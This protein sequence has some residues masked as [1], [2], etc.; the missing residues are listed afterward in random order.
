[1][2]KFVYVKIKNVYGKELVYPDCKVSE[3]I[4]KLSNKKTLNDNDLLAMEELGYTL[5]TRT[6]KYVSPCGNVNIT[7]DD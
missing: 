3:I 6:T 1:M 7:L 5:A 2:Q 4:A